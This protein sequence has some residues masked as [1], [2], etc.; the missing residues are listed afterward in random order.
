MSVTLTPIRSAGISQ[1]RVLSAPE[2]L[3]ESEIQNKVLAETGSDTSQVFDL[4][5]MDEGHSQS[6]I[7]IP[8]PRKM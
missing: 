1:K 8:V 7:K 5:T 4:S 2:D 3:V 6:V